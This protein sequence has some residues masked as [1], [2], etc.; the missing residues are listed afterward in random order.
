[1]GTKLA[2]LDAGV[3]IGHMELVATALELRACTLGS[4]PDEALSELLCLNKNQIPLACLAV[5]S[6]S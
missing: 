6:R 1:M 3:T 2:L 5:G 4:L